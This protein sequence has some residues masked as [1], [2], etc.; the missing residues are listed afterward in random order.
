M[1]IEHKTKMII[2]FVVVL[3]VVAVLVLVAIKGRTT[4][5]ATENPVVESSDGVNI[6]IISEGTGE[7][8]V[9]GDAISVNYAGMLTDGTVFDS[10]ID[11]KFNHVEPYEFVLGAGEVIPGWD[12]GLVGM[13]VGEKRIIEVSPEYAYGATGYPPVIPPNATLVFQVELVEIIK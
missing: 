4:P 7:G 3:A 11:P 5:I 1:Q 10:N 9:S 8:I 2:S 12:V 6:A 13:K